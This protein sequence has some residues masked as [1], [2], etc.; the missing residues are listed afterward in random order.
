[1]ENTFLKRK[2]NGEQILMSELLAAPPSD[3]VLMELFPYS[4]DT[5]PAS[6]PIPSPNAL[7]IGTSGPAPCVNTSQT[8]PSLSFWLEISI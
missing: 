5:F 6:I 3:E 4:K 8:L 1:M 7:T 2:A